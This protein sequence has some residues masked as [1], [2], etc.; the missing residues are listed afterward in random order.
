MESFS[1]EEYEELFEK[2]KDGTVK[3]DRDY[4]KGLKNDNF[5]NVNLNII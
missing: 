5:P 4:E 1:V 2:L 3:V